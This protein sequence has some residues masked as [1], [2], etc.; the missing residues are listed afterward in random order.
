MNPEDLK[1]KT[2]LIT[3]AARGIGLGIAVDF[4]KQ[5]INIALLDI[6]D[7][8]GGM[9]IK[10]YRLANSS[11]LDS[12]T[13]EI[14]KLG[15]KAIGIQ[16][17]VRNLEAMKKAVDSTISELGG[18]DIVVANAGVGIWSPFEDM[19]EK[20]WKDVIDVN[21]TGVANTI[22]ASLPQLKNTK[23]REY[24]HFKLYWRKAG[25]TRSCQLRFH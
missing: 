22:W 23:E 20:Q 21:L 13:K 25:S 4:A 16:A 1:G 5:G 14:Q 19:N 10:G 15:V 6:A 12:A 7:P 18:L 3:G 17:D 24:N 11:E 8:T 2:A 9:A